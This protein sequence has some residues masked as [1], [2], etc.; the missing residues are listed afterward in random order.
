MNEGRD[1]IKSL[2]EMLASELRRLYGLL[3]PGGQV[4]GER[5]NETPES[6]NAA[7]QLTALK[8]QIRYECTEIYRPHLEDF[9]LIYFLELRR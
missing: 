6:P 7:R 2:T 4:F 1:L 8:Y 9:K 3:C 5:A